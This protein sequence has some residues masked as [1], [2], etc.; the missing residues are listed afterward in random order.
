MID[1]IR[2]NSAPIADAC[3]R[4]GV[5]R[6]EVFGSAARGD[7]RPGESDVDFLAEFRPSSGRLLSRYL[8]LAESLERLLGTHVDVLTL[9]SLKNPYLRRSVEASKESVYAE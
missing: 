2:E 7:Y 6:L 5:Q 9:S 1:L 8:G 4:F 3:R